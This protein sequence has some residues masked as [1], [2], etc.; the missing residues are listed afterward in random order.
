MLPA[1]LYIARLDSKRKRKETNDQTLHH[2]EA[3][4]C[5]RELAVENSHSGACS[6]MNFS[7][8]RGESQLRNYPKAKD[9]EIL[10]ELNFANARISRYYSLHD[11]HFNWIITENLV[12]ARGFVAKL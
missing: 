10:V 7:E 12:Y 11:S 3:R 9:Y 4:S 1:R 5:A 6:L 2:R 8:R